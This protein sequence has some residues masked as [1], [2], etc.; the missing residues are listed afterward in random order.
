MHDRLRI[1]ANFATAQIGALIAAYPELQDDEELL[2][3]A[4]EGETDFD[5]VMP[6]LMDAFLER[7]AMKEALTSI[8]S[9]MRERATRFDR[10]ADAFKFLMLRLMNAA[11]MTKLTLPVATLS[12]REGGTSVNVLDEA[13]LPQGMFTKT[14]NK[15]AIKSAILAGDNIPGA[16]LVKGEPGLSIRTK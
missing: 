3:S 16:E 4:L 1:D 14:P 13:Q 12:I 6:K 10:G 7:V 8:M 2:R 11:G 9:N 5:R 15:T